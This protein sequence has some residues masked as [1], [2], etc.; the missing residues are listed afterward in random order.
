MD[1]EQDILFQFDQRSV[2]V[3][4]LPIYNTFKNA[5]STANKPPAL[6][7]RATAPLEPEAEAAD[8]VADA[9]PEPDAVAPDPVVVADTVEGELAVTLAPG[10]CVII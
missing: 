5:S 7:S 9:V 4:R 2:R 1:P 10:P 6:A 8:P 3:T